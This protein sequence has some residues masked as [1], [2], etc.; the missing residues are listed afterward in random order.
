MSYDNKQ[1]KKYADS[2]SRIGS[3]SWDEIK[4]WNGIDV[5]PDDMDDLSGA[6]ADP[7]A[8]KVVNTYPDQSLRVKGNSN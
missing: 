3:M 8:G 6:G 5:N 7:D 1:N 4:K 2:R